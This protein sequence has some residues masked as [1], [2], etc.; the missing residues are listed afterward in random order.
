MDRTNSLYL[1][2][3][4]AHIEELH[5]VRKTLDDRISSLLEELANE[6]W[7]ADDYA[8]MKVHP[9]ARSYL[10]YLAGMDFGESFDFDPLDPYIKPMD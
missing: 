7:F 9:D 10:E 8:G 5:S 3:M 2:S 6:A 1:A 4:V